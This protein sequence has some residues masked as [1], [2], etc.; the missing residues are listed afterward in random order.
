MSH[1]IG[2]AAITTL[3]LALSMAAA[4]SAVAADPHG[5]SPV[6][7]ELFTAEGCSSCPPADNFL[8]QLDAAQPIPGAHLIVLGEHVDYW[9]QQGWPDP[10]SSAALTERQRDYERALKVH[11]PFTPQFIVDGGAEM[12]LSERQ[13]IPQILKAAAAARKIPV[14]IESLGVA[15][16]SP[17]YVTG[18]I[19]VDG[20]AERHRSEVYV[21][22]AL[23]HFESKVLRGENRGQ[24]LSHVAVL[25]SLVKL[26]ALAPGQQWSQEFRVPLKAGVDPGN[27]RVIGFVQE[28]DYGKVVGAALQ[29]TASA[30]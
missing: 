6:L 12:R 3:M 26:G 7:I 13:K 10:F 28:S 29:R 14:S 16:G 19:V 24:T 23:D 30:G 20:N 25:F 18:K 5:E 8:R 4:R 27:V 22:L 1:A 11:E 15:P 2:A 21:A 9:D 17:S